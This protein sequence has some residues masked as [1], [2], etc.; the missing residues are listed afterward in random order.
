MTKILS[1]GNFTHHH[2]ELEITNISEKDFSGWKRHADF[3]YIII[4]GGDG[5]LR[6]V[7]SK[8]QDQLEGKIFILNPSGSF[9]VVAKMNQVP[10]VRDIL[11]RLARGKDV[12]TRV[13]EIYH[14]NEH[15]FFFSAG[16]MGDLLHIVFSEILR[17][18]FLKKRGVLRY[19]VSV[20]L[21]SPVFLVITPFML[22][23][24]GRFFIYTPFRFI[25]RL[26]SF[27]GRVP[28]MTK[29]YESA[30]HMVELDGDVVMV[31]GQRMDI[32][33]AGSFMLAELRDP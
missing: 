6:R 19:L 10:A 17:I 32:G 7:I 1:I 4:N 3:R 2:P 30:Y 5:T 12:Q 22:M 29:Q 31:E 28:E 25:R 18:G 14:L 13:Q 27:Y 33:P 8:L 11:E 26:G 24:P 9:N 15:L 21:L 16:N 23:S 20:V